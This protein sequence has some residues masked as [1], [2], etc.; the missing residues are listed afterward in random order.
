MEVCE[1]DLGGVIWFLLEQVPCW[2]TLL[3]GDWRCYNPDDLWPR[4][5]PA[6]AMDAHQMALA[7]FDL[8]LPGDFFGIFT[9]IFREFIEHIIS[10][11]W[12]HKL[13]HEALR[14][15]FRPPG[16]TSLCSNSGVCRHHYVVTSLCSNSNSNHLI[17]CDHQS[18]ISNPS[19]SN[20]RPNQAGHMGSEH[21]LDICLPWVAVTWWLF[22]LISIAAC[23]S[24]WCPP[25]QVTQSWYR[26]TLPCASCRQSTTAAISSIPPAHYPVIHIHKI[27]KFGCAHI[28]GIFWFKANGRVEVKVKCMC[29]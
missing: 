26:Q 29:G 22:S 18:H 4:P 16:T 20:Q 12:S 28:F 5:S 10:N 23:F 13:G 25:G 2:D 21:L 27:G 15:K 7:C 8:V 3:H 11:K 1:R 6:A 9:V 14:H 17:S 24:R 19:W